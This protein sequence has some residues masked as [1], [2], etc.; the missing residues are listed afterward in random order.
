[1]DT[2]IQFP[3]DDKR[4]IARPA[5]MAAVAAWA[6]AAR[7]PAPHPGRR[8]GVPGEGIDGPDRV[9]SEAGQWSVPAGSTGGRICAAAFRIAGEPNCPVQ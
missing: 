6:S 8:R 5:V 1:L 2:L 3:N 9:P 4:E 7:A